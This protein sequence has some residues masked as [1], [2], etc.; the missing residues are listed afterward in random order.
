MTREDSVAKRAVRRSTLK[1]LRAKKGERLK[2]LKEQYNNDIREVNIQY[3]ED[4]ERLRAKYAAGDYAKSERERKHADRK[5]QIEKRRIERTSR[6][7]EFSAGEEIFS[8]IVQGVG[9][10]VS[11]AAT[12]LIIYT[13]VADT[14]SVNRKIYI[15]T[16]ACF[17][18]SMVLMYIMSTLHHSLVP[19]AAKEVFKR[20]T[21]D[22]IFIVLGSAYTCF[23]LTALKGTTGWI[24]FG[25]VWGA[26]IVGIVLYSIWGS[27]LAIAN[28]V[29][30]LVIGWAG[31]VLAGRLYHVLPAESFGF[32]LTAGITYSISC[33]FYM[34]QKVKFMHAVSDSIMLMSSVYIFLAMFFAVA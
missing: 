13:A 4:P 17:G 5:I 15:I 8:S 28:L 19:P 32:L 18:G 27:E 6:E 7:R 1:S 30:Y 24:L 21:H 16:Y 29:L 23:T 31:V 22:F 3:A 12:V 2:Q 14:T 34:L 9:A 11:V 20:L 26:S 10:L 33:V 25:I